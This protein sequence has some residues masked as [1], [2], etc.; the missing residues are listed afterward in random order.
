MSQQTLYNDLVITGDLTVSGTTTTINTSNLTVEDKNIII[1]NVDT[2]SNSTGD[3]GGLTLKAASD[4]TFN[5]VSGADRWTSNV[6]VEASALVRTG[7]TTAQFLKADGTTQE[8][9]T[10]KTIYVDAG[11]GTDIRTGFNDHDISKPF[12][13]IGKAVSDSVSGD[14]V[15]VR[16]GYYTIST[17]ISLDGKGNIYFETGTDITVAGNTVAFS[18]TANETKTVN[19]FAQFTLSG[20]ADMLTQSNGTLFL[21]YQSITSTSTDTLF[22]ISGGTLNTSFASIVASTTDGF[23]LTGS[24][25][26]IIR[27]SHTAS[28]KQFLNCNTSGAVTMDIWTVVGASTDATIRVVNHT[29]FSYRGVNLNSNSPSP[30]PPS[31]CI[32]F[33]YTE[34][35]NSPVLRNL[36]L[37]TSGTGISIDTTNATRDIFLDQIKINAV[38][39]LSSTA[40]TTVYST[41]TYSTVA[42]DTNVTVDGQYNIMSNL[43]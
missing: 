4:K 36:R 42:P 2:P 15:Y 6:G 17:Q 8:L 16:A 12:K 27:R 3:G 20:T 24:G 39:S 31:P 23:V 11:V 40:P 32:V 35:T 25:T 7:G 30:N 18:L 5:W 10:G 26:L 13:T 38:N 43:F 41:T 37:T 34:G 22:R 1:G 9:T 19:G 28:C 33:A 14:T 29:G 21:E